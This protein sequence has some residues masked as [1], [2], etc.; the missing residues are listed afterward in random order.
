MLI[1]MSI[2]AAPLRTASRV[3]NTLALVVPA[4]RG[5]PTTAMAFVLQPCSRRAQ[6]ATFDEFTQTVANP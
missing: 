5:K 1:T 6:S 3:S 4:P 2:S